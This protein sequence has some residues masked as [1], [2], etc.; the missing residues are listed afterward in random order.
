M[1]WTITGNF[2]NILPIDWSKSFA[3]QMHMP[4]L[5]LGERPAETPDDEIE[6]LS[7][8]DEQ[9][10]NDLDMHAL[11]LGGLQTTDNGHFQTAEEVMK[12]IDDIMDEQTPSEGDTVENEVMEKAKEVLGSP[13]YED[14]EYF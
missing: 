6:D 4:T 12:E 14:S 7:S 10:A 11:I 2:G 1:F 13:L 9:V 8:E 5:K 3:R